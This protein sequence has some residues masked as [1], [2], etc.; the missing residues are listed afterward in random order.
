[1]QTAYL[2]RTPF[3]RF[4]DEMKC[5]DDQQKLLSSQYT[6][7]YVYVYLYKPTKDVAEM[8][9][10]LQGSFRESPVCVKDIRCL[11]M[12]MFSCTEP[13]PRLS[14]QQFT[15]GCQLPVL[16]LTPEM[17]GTHSL[18]FPACADSAF[19]RSFQA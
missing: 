9:R 3:G 11:F 5:S 4:R 8:F 16:L 2:H 14:G 7:T 18:L 1:M 17:P 15:G 10:F 6:Y 12:P 13:H 19:R